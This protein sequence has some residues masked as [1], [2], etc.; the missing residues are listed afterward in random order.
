MDPGPLDRSGSAPLQKVR[1][2]RKACTSGLGRGRPLAACVRDR[3]RDVRAPPSTPGL[4]HLAMSPRSEGTAFP[5]GLR[6]NEPRPHHVRVEACG[7][8]GLYVWRS[9]H[10]HSPCVHPLPH[11]LSLRHSRLLPAISVHAGVHPGYAQGAF[12]ATSSCLGD[13]EGAQ[14]VQ[15]CPLGTQ[16]STSLWVLIIY[17]SPIYHALDYMTCC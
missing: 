11:S 1:R 13:T 16:S 3:A 14:G 5:P 17:S 10:G 12:M 2:A 6:V 9:L 4:R 7:N 8:A 15:S